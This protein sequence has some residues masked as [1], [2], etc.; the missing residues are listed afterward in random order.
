MEEEADL[1]SVAA[2]HVEENVRQLVELTGG[3]REGFRGDGA[4]VVER[5]GREPCAAAGGT[6]GSEE[7]SQVRLTIER[8]RTLVLAA[9]V[10]L[11]V[12]LGVFLAVAKCRNPF[13]RRDLPKRLGIDIQQEANG[14]TYSHALGAHSQFKI[15]ASKVVQ[16]KQGIV[17]L[18]DVKIELY[19]RRRQPRGPHRGRRVRIRPEERQGDG[20]GAG[21]DYA[22]AAGG[23]A[24]DCAQG[25]RGC[26][27]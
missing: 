22:D 11:V 25:D 1:D 12:A 14:V 3:R 16:L 15:H 19:G 7:L 9:G 24:G 26:R 8:M 5:I 27:R 20:R 6:A 10:L 18:H 21:G 17:Q 13:N 23:G 4:A 2:R